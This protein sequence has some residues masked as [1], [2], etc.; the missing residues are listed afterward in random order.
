[1]SESLEARK[2]DVFELAQRAVALGALDQVGAVEARDAHRHG[3][4]EADGD[5]LVG[6]VDVSEV[7]AAPA[8]PAS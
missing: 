4:A 7:A 1:M 2:G 8:R 6:R 3:G 5:D